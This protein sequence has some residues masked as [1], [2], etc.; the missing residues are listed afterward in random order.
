MAKN[1][2]NVESLLNDLIHRISDKG[3]S[4]MDKLV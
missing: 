2:D 1:I 3:S 4:E